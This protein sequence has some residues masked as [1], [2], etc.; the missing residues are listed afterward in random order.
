MRTNAILDTCQCPLFLRSLCL[1]PDLF[2]NPHVHFGDLRRMLICCCYLLLHSLRRTC[3]GH[4]RA[5]QFF[6]YFGAFI[7]LGLLGVLPIAGF[8]NLIS[9]LDKTLCQQFFTNNYTCEG[10]LTFLRVWGL[11]TVFIL[12]ASLFLGFL[13]FSEREEQLRKAGKLPNN[14][15]ALDEDEHNNLTPDVAVQAKSGRSGKGNGGAGAG[16]FGDR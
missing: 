15:T 7:E 11:I 8:P 9:S 14:A 1:V 4:F 6:V 12:A 2:F 10:Y 16:S 13:D 3:T 5:G